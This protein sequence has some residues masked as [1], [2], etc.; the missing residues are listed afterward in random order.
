ME[1][2]QPVGKRTQSSRL[3]LV[4]A[5]NVVMI[6]GLVVVGL[7]SH[8]L[9]VLAA[10]GDYIADSAAIALGL[11]AIRVSRHPR[12][13]K[14][15]T[16]FVAFINAGFLLLASGFVVVEALRRLASRSPEIHGPST[17]IVS[18]IAM[19]AM[20]IGAVI[21]GDDDDDDNEDDNGDGDGDLHMKSVMLDT[22]AD[23]AAAGAVA[24]AGGII[25]FT[26]RYFWLDP[27]I[28]IVVAVVV[29]Y[30]AARL[31]RKALRA[32]TGPSTP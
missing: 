3:L 26:G 24:L 4:L 2:A 21:L 7:T 8:S 12:G 15:A 32:L 30:H 10:G 6:V 19:V 25:Y 16:T 23:A 11:V 31:L 27:S 17:M 28:A 14:K 9:G 18:L 20:I 29:G 5:I 13:H 22:I 1:A